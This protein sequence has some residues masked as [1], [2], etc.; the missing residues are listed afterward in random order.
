MKNFK[1]ATAGHETE[2]G[3]LLSLATRVTCPP[4]GPGHCCSEPRSQGR[5]GQTN[6]LHTTLQS[7]P[8]GCSSGKL[9]LTAC[10]RCRK[11]QEIFPCLHASSFPSVTSQLPY[12]ALSPHHLTLGT[13]LVTCFHQEG[14]IGWTLG[15]SWA[16][17]LGRFTAFFPDD[18][19][20][21]Q[22]EVSLPEEGSPE[23]RHPSVPAD[24]LSTAPQLSEPSEKRGS[25]CKS[26]QAPKGT[27]PNKS[28]K[29]AWRRQNSTKLKV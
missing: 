10:G 29:A 6:S 16:W 8:P 19:G 28:Q 27:K 4:G 1:M 13:G 14:L 23:P 11:G 2:C 9:M 17:A 24:S 26:A 15:Q 12:S 22:S 18:L 21:L 3:A 25:K 20:T 7:S 5:K